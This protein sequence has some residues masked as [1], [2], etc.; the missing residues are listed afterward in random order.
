MTQ[1]WI[2]THCHIY[3]PDGSGTE[4]DEPGSVSE[5]LDRA[6][7]AGVH[8][9]V[10]VGI[11]VETSQM[12][13]RIASEDQRCAATAGLH[14]NSAGDFS[15]SVA[16]A[17]EQLARMPEVAAVGETGL[18]FY[19][20]GAPRDVQEEVFRFHIGLGRSTG[21][22]IVVH[23]REAHGAVR[24]I[25]EDEAAGEGLPPIVM[26]CFQ[27]SAADAAAYLS[28]GAYL[29]FAGPITF[30]TATA[31]TLREVAASVP[32]DRCLVETDSPFLSPHPYRGERNEPARVAVIGR[33]LAALKGLAEGEVSR[34]T[35]ETAAK[36]FFGE[37]R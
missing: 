29:S 13:A 10:V 33:E 19:R 2:D 27:G 21:K 16:S 26:H 9:V 7:D 35:T 14:P 15:D 34:L 20:M 6:E 1:S 23:V 28:L 4:G 25:L 31:G 3:L 11:D 8:R 22:P 17:L 12:A 37:R 30:R 36:L 5:I 32:L 18:D 24:D